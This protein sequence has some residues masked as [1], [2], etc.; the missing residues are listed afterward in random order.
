MNEGA[1][2]HRPTAAS[3]DKGL[4]QGASQRPDV[5]RHRRRRSCTPF[6]SLVR[7]GPDVGLGVVIFQV[8]E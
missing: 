2:P 7:S 8:S 4:E 5:I 1:T 3:R 6:P